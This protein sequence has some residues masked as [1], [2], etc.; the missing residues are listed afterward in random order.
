M[1]PIP[2][3]ASWCKGLIIDSYN[4]YGGIKDDW[5]KV[6]KNEKIEWILLQKGTLSNILKLLKNDWK[7]EYEEERVIIFKKIKSNGKGEEKWVIIGK[8]LK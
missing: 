8:K 6:I 5:E 2:A 7:I 4:F 3:G 1:I